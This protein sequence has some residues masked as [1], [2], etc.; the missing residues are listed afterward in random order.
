VI[1][2]S[3]IPPRLRGS[4]PLP[5][6][7]TRRSYGRYRRH[8]ALFPA[9]PS[10]SHLLT[11]LL[12][13]TFAG[14][15]L[16]SLAA[17]PMLRFGRH[18]E[19]SGGEIA[20]LLQPVRWTLWAQRGLT[21]CLRVLLFGLAATFLGS[22]LYLVVGEPAWRDVVWLPALG[23]AVLGLLL[24]LAQDVTTA[25]AARFVDRKL[26]LY[27]RLATALE[28]QASGATSPHA[29]AQIADATVRAR[30]AWLS[31]TWARRGVT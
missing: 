26:N 8:A 7:S 15:E 19:R 25:D 30:R 31:S 1:S 24:A 6:W 16:P 3:A 29:Q 11:H 5:W 4:L 27:A 21:L 10:L 17:G 23:A 18:R 9:A 13:L 14:S 12:R 2:L 22:L 28:L 20:A